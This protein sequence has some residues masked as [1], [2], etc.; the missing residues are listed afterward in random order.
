MPSVFANVKKRPILFAVLAIII[1]LINI[2]FLVINYFFGSTWYF[3]DNLS[4]AFYFLSFIV[5]I[6]LLIP[7]IF[8]GLTDCLSKVIAV[9]KRI[10][11]GVI[12]AI[13]LTCLIIWSWITGCIL[14]GT[15]SGI[16]PTAD[17]KDRSTATNLPTIRLEYQNTVSLTL[18]CKQTDYEVL[19]QAKTIYFVEYMDI[20]PFNIKFLTSFRISKE[21]M[22]DPTAF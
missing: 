16:L 11:K 3:F 21:D 6:S 2:Y 1:S 13:S 15:S 19:K 10:L 14:Q 22:L 17:I 8:F 4:L 7:L 20:E 12:F 5:V 18:Y 9:K